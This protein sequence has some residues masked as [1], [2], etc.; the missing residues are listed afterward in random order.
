MAVLFYRRFNLIWSA[1]HA[2]RELLLTILSRMAVDKHDIDRS[3]LV[4]TEYL[5]NLIRHS[6]AEDKSVKLVISRS[7]NA[8]KIELIESAPSFNPCWSHNMEN[9]IY[10][11]NLRDSGMGLAL[12]SHYTPDFHYVT[13]NN[14]NYFS[15]LLP[16]NTEKTR[17]VLLDDEKASL[18]LLEAYVSET[19]QCVSFCSEDQA[20]EYII[21]HHV[22]LLLIDMN[23][24]Y[25]N[26]AQFL[27]RIKKF[28]HLT[29]IG[30]III[31]ADHSDKSMMKAVC[32][33]VDDYLLKPVTKNKLIKVCERVLAR[34]VS[35]NIVDSTTTISKESYLL[36]KVNAFSFGSIVTNTGGDFMNHH[37]F[38]QHTDLIVLGDA[39]G[40]GNAANKIAN[41]TKA[42]IGGFCQT[43]YK[44]LSE[45]T[46]GLSVSL[47]K[48][49]FMQNTIVTLLV[50]EI[51]DNQIRWSS[52]GHPKIMSWRK[53]LG[54]RLLGTDQPFV[55]LVNEYEYT[56][57][58][59]VLVPGELLFLVT[60]G[61]F[62]NDD[63]VRQLDTFMQ[64]Q[65]GAILESDTALA[66]DVWQQ[67][68]LNLSQT[69]DDASIVI[70]SLKSQEITRV[71]K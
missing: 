63:N 48:Q 61:V 52:M 49:D 65:I 42:F 66:A 50:L 44:G 37:Q 23:L 25:M 22:D 45:F 39:M 4:V 14:Q 33:G 30:I 17:I 35:R 67:C 16:I 43:P 36:R 20:Y 29:D 51:K 71:S 1:L 60:D 19:Y 11:G 53:D 59:H 10:D 34:R 38:E 3:G 28:E 58:F 47:S 15:F 70:L 64:E 26:A 32:S 46:K 62:E 57:D 24:S 27:S 40:H 69:L 56:F 6:D 13:K 68:L 18:Q 12:I 31:S 9:N 21:S 41:S 5:S 7:S 55:G 2:I 54:F 8:V